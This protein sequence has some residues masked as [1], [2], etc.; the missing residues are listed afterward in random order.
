MGSVLW[1]QHFLKIGPILWLGKVSLLICTRPD[2]AQ[3]GSFPRLPCCCLQWSLSQPV[4]WQLQLTLP[5]LARWSCLHLMGF[6][7]KDT[8]ADFKMMRLRM[9]SLQMLLCLPQVWHHLVKLMTCL[10]LPIQAAFH[11]TGASVEA[12]AVS[13]L[14]RGGEPQKLKGIWKPGHQIVSRWHRFHDTSS[15][16]GKPLER[17]SM[18]RF[19]VYGGASFLED[20]TGEKCWQRNHC[21]SLRLFN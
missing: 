8:R 3:L 6:E 13:L 17:G 11:Q 4:L 9:T 1:S 19:L 18:L 7:I 15:T 16:H 2:R 14:S 5:L 10:R 12:C 20:T 21:P